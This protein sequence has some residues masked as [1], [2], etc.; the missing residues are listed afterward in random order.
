MIHA[1][2]PFGKPSSPS[3]ARPGKGAHNKIPA[4][5]EEAVALARRGR[6]RRRDD[7]LPEGFVA[8]LLRTLARRPDLAKL[9]VHILKRTAA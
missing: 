1:D 9:L 8:R 3:A 4:T 6:P 5:F 2:L 7:E